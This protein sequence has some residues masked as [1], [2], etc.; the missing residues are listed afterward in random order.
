MERAAAEWRYDKR[1]KARPYHDG[2]FPDDL[3]L[4]SDKRSE[5]HP[6]HARDGVTFWVANSDVAPHDHF[7]GGT[8]DCDDPACQAQAAAEREAVE[9]AELEGA[10]PAAD[11]VDTD[12]GTHESTDQGEEPDHTAG[13]EQH[14]HTS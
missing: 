2:T 7:L 10:S 5:T 6:Y 14:R 11:D 4:W 1:H 3:E 13:G 9:D 8:A 12:E